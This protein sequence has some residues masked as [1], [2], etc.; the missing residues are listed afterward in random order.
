MQVMVVS[1][2]LSGLRRYRVKH[3]LDI[4]ACKCEEIVDNLDV[5]LIEFFV[6]N[7]IVVFRIVVGVVTVL[8]VE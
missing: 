5:W 2:K 1:G 8:A 4:S 3:I 7:F 6:S